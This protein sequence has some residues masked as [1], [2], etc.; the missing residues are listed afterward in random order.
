MNLKE[1]F[2]A[3]QNFLIELYKKTCGEF[4]CYELLKIKQIKPPLNKYY[5]QNIE[6]LS[7][8]S[9][10]KNKIEPIEKEQY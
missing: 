9:C 1:T 6:L 7:E 8:D 3:T 2:F 4:A 10:N 5:W